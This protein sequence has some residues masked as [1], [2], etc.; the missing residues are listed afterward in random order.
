MA[1]VLRSSGS[2]DRRWGRLRSSELEDRRP[3]HLRRTPPHLRRTPPSSTFGAE[4]RRI[5]PSTIF[6]AEERRTPLPSSILDLRPR[7]SKNPP[8]CD[9]WPRRMIRRSDRRL[10]VARLL[11]RWGGVLRRWGGF[12]DLPAP[13]NE[14]P[15]PISDFRGQK[16]EEPPPTSHFLARK[17]EESLPTFCSSYDPPLDQPSQGPLSSSGIWIF[18]SI[19][20]LKEQFEDRDRPPIRT[21]R[22]RRRR[23]TTTVKTCR[24]QNPDIPRAGRGGAAHGGA[25][26]RCGVGRDAD[27]SVRP[28]DNRSF[29]PPGNR[30]QLS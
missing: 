30:R 12:F 1:G 23:R 11:R 6:E 26:G 27:G 18:S 14:E 28:E 10:G 7:R 3:P 5:P 25:A 4:D 2:E 29:C 22:R 16:N 13:K 24:I 21:R 9:L 15:P 8:I 20:H 19:F 17:N